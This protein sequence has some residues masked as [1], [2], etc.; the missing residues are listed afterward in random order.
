MR[1]LSNYR[2]FKKIIFLDTFF[3]YFR[4]KVHTTNDLLHGFQPH[5]ISDVQKI[6]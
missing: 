3:F 6:D 5:S 2:H 1:L 4:I